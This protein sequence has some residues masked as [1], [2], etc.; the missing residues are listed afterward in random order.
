MSKTGRF[1]FRRGT[2]GTP[3]SERR[4]LAECI[5]RDYDEQGQARMEPV[6]P[7]RHHQHRHDHGKLIAHSGVLK[8]ST[9]IREVGRGHR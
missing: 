6:D 9:P 1:N 4:F 2:R 3:K 7:L 8:S 5:R